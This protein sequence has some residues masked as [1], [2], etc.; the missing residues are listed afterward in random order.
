MPP[1]FLKLV[2]LDKASDVPELAL[3]GSCERLFMRRLLVLLALCCG[4]AVKAQSQST[5]A[6]N[7][8]LPLTNSAPTKA[9][10]SLELQTAG[11]GL[12]T[13]TFTELKPNEV[14]KGT[15]I[16]SGIAIEAVKKRRPLQFINPLAPPEYGSPE[17]NAARDPI[18]GRVTGLKIFAIRF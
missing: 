2:H 7:T 18:N 1:K 9:G 15:H 11:V 4:F 10:Q 17:D 5:N 12:S 13:I 3:S 8:K 6:P 14:I 16:Y